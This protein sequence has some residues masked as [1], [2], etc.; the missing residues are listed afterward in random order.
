M[1]V[2]ARRTP[3]KA[4]GDE[5]ICSAC[6]QS[7]LLL[8]NRQFA[9]PA[10]GGI[11]KTVGVSLDLK[12]LKPLSGNILTVQTASTDIKINYLD[13]KGLFECGG[14]CEENSR[15]SGSRRSNL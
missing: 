7:V 5:A 3:A 2:I 13:L 11:A 9:S 6:L 8:T 14:H 4:G 12:G 1:A 15:E 10:Y